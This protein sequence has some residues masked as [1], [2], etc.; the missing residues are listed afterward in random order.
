MPEVLNSLAELWLLFRS[1]L[2]GHL[3][4]LS[5]HFFTFE[6]GKMTPTFHSSKDELT[7][8]RLKHFIHHIFHTNIPPHSEYRTG[9]QVEALGTLYFINFVPIRL[10][11]LSVSSSVRFPQMLF[12]G[13][14]PSPDLL[15]LIASV[16]VSLQQSNKPMT[17][18][19]NASK[20]FPFQSNRKEQLDQ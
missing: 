20:G 5:L 14:Y 17:K 8:Y 6:M 16:G 9:I 19:T 13:C 12:L 15:F 11:L 3:I 7:Q 1:K 4:F 10:D 18:A 2:L